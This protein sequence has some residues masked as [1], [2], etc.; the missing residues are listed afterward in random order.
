[1]MVRVA[2]LRRWA[3]VAS[4]LVAPATA[5]NDEP[6]VVR[7]VSVE[8]SGGSGGNA[9]GA[10]NAGDAGSAGSAGERAMTGG[11]SA[12]GG[13]G[14]VADAG[15][16]ASDAGVQDAAPDGMPADAGADAADANPRLPPLC[17]RLDNS[18]STA[19]NLVPSYFGA[20]HEDC[21]VAGLVE[22]PVLHEWGNRLLRW[23]LD[24]WGCNEDSPPAGFE[25][26]D[27]Q[28]NVT[29]SSADIALLIDLYLDR[30]H[31]LVDLSPG[32]AA[33]L[34]SDLELLAEAA[35][36]EPGDDHPNARCD[37]GSGGAGGAAGAGNAA[38]AGGLAGAGGSAGS[39]AVQ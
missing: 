11:S 18:Q 28:A 38:G 19:V 4:F 35:S 29:V 10:A 22:N 2:S 33:Q 8:G 15:S 27:A 37:D 16:G 20:L 3:I 24:L 30:T 21:R 36:A 5:C 23:T 13:G 34:R 31:R 32:E 1:M 6:L 25:L 7:I 12:G 26:V 14:D 9:G 39:G 17:L